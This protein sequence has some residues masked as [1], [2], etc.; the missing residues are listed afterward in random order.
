MMSEFIIMPEACC[1]PLP[2]GLDPGIASL[3]E[4]LSIAIYATKLAGTIEG[5]TIAILGTG[6]IGISIL[7]S[8]LNVCESR[9]YAT[10]LIDE[11]LKMADY[12][13]A[14]WTGNR[15]K[16]DICAQILELEPNGVDIVFECCGKQEAMDDA[17]EILKP[18]GK[19]VIAGIP[20]F[21]NWIIPADV[22]RRKEINFYNV[23]RQNDCL[24][25]AVDLI[26]EGDIDP[27]FLITH[28]FSFPDAAQ[29]FEIV[30]D[31]RDGVMKALIQF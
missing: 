8:V 22:A 18:G 14:Y 29:A 27:E 30:A 7:L 15:E 26:A 21:D 13:G 12:A 17:I 28:N 1:F 2:P 3:A 20:E 16:N 4:P 31:Y 19:I 5:K 24:E 9:V 11:R 6:P 23:R 25:Q 10:D